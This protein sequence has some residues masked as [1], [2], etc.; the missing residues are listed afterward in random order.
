MM[1]YNMRYTRSTDI[2]HNLTNVSFKNYN[3]SDTYPI[4]MQDLH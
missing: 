2:A 3:Y 1:V 4:I